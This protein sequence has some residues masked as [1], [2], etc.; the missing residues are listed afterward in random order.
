[1]AF[2]FRS[3]LSD[4]SYERRVN[5]LTVWREKHY[6]RKV[7][8]EPDQCGQSGWNSCGQTRVCPQRMIT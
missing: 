8:L 7:P 2:C 1:M 3:I 5:T 4:V 6:L